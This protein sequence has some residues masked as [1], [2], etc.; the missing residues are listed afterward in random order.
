MA[1]TPVVQKVAIL[2]INLELFK[3]LF[4]TSTHLLPR[5]PCFASD[6][7]KSKME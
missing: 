4:I 3:V 2:E 1:A 6:K 7:N 5:S